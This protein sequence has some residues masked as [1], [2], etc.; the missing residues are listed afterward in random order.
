MAASVRSCEAE[1]P[2]LTRSGS[3][4]ICPNARI[5]DNR[6]SKFTSLSNTSKGSTARSSLSSPST[7]AASVRSCE[8]EL[9]SLTKSGSFH[10]CPNARIADKR[11]SKF[12]SLSNTSSG[13]TARSCPSSP[14]ASDADLR[15]Y[16]ALLDNAAMS[17][18]HLFR[19]VSL[20]KE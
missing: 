8:V 20:V 17:R 10:I 2:S 16:I 3:F 15:T 11:I 6:I 9:P 13:S 4:H 19:M 7:V 18:S 5:A 14:S 12:T 1:L